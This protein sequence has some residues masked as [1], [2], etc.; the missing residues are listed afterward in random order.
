MFLPTARPY[1]IIIIYIVFWIWLARD[2]PHIRY[3]VGVSEQVCTLALNIRPEIRPDD[4]HL[5][6]LFSVTYPITGGMLNS[7]SGL[8]ALARYLLLSNIRQIL[9]PVHPYYTFIR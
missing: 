2:A 1:Q 8:C 4:R 3:P 9:Y 7:E 6:G 5:A